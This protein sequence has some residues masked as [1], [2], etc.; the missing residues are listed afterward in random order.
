MKRVSIIGGA[1]AAFIAWCREPDLMNLAHLVFSKAMGRIAADA[2][3][4]NYQEE[5][6]RISGKDTD[7]KKGKGKDRNRDKGKQEDILLFREKINKLKYSIEREKKALES[8][9]RLSHAKKTKDYIRSLIDQCVLQ[10]DAYMNTLI[11]SFEARGSRRKDLLKQRRSRKEQ[12]AV[13]IVPC[14]TELFS[15][16][17]SYGYLKE[18]LGGEKEFKALRIS[19]ESDIGWEICNFADGQRNLLEIRDAISAEYRPVSVDDI[20]AMLSLLET[21]SL[22][23]FQKK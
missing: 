22:I 17:L 1:S 7:K 10:S 3:F 23:S 6:K 20:K 19:P 9:A 13:Q 8:I 15:T 4:I 21:A 5:K 16:P 18:V 11:C 14:R 12:L 2:V